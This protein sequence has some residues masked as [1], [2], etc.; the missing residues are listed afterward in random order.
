MLFQLSFSRSY[1]EY[2]LNLDCI[3]FQAEK[4]KVASQEIQKQLQEQM[5]FIDQKKILVEEDLSKVEPALQDAKMAVQSIK[6]QHLVRF[7][8]FVWNFHNCGHFRS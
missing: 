7:C 3:H 2:F 1:F 5:V 8:K 6:R 4:K